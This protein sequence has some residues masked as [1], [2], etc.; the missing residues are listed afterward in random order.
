MS[1]SLSE[2]II[3]LL[4]SKGLSR[5]RTGAGQV[6]EFWGKE[7]GDRLTIRIQRA[8]EKTVPNDAGEPTTVKVQE[9][10]GLCYTISFRNPKEKPHPVILKRDGKELQ[11]TTMEE[12]MAVY[13]T[14]TQRVEDGV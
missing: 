13:D 7:F 9:C 4:Q 11:V 14:W 5:I 12:F 6:S 1:Q 2:A 8:G 10:V 3:P